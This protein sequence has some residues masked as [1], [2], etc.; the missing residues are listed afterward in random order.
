MV[1]LTSKAEQHFVDLIAAEGVP[2]LNVRVSAVNVGLPN[3]DIA[4]AFC[5]PG[6]EK[7]DDVAI[8]FPTFTLWIDGASET[9]LQDAQL[10]F[11]ED[12]LGGGQLSIHAPQLRKNTGSLKERVEAVLEYEINPNLAAHRGYVS[13][14]DIS[15]GIVIL[16]FGGGCHGCGMVNVTLKHGIEKTLKEKFPEIREVRDVTDHSEGENPYC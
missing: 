3:A 14:V 6:E 12:S 15:D 7:A 1:V 4:L 16:Q 9:T 10:D 11:V 2:G 8:P 13:L 5:E